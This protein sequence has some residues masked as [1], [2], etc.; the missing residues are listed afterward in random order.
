LGAVGYSVYVVKTS[1]KRGV[2]TGRRKTKT[3]E[4]GKGRELDSVG[5]SNRS[6]QRKREP[7][8]SKTGGANQILAELGSSAPKTRGKKAFKRRGSWRKGSGR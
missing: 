1:N 5:N 2:E 3:R 7:K 4:V 6:G 8:S